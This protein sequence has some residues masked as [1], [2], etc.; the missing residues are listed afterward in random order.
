MRKIVLLTSL[1]LVSFLFTGC[2]STSF[3]FNATPVKIGG[4]IRGMDIK[5]VR[6]KGVNKKA[7]PYKNYED[8]SNITYRCAYNFALLG[9]A[10]KALENGY[11]YFTLE[12]PEGSNYAPLSVNSISKLDRYCNAPHWDKETS[13]LEDKC[14]HI[15]L[16]NGTPFRVKSMKVKYFKSRNPMIPVWSAKKTKQETWKTLTEEC[17]VGKMDVLNEMMQDYNSI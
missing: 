5:A 10:T 3:W 14:G 16:G 9:V 12:F 2:G 15:G 11:G 8:S 13:L 1:V 6:V 7:Y 4:E 17:F